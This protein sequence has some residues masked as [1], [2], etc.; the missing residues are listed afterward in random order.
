MSIRITRLQ[1]RNLSETPQIG[2]LAGSAAYNKSYNN[3][4][5]IL[6]H[7][8]VVY[9][10]TFLKPPSKWTPETFTEVAELES[11]IAATNL[12]TALPIRREDKLY[13]IHLSSSPLVK[14]RFIP[15]ARQSSKKARL[16]VHQALARIK[17]G[18]AAVWTCDTNYFL[19]RRVQEGFYFYTMNLQGRPTLMFFSCHRLMVDFVQETFGCTEQSKYFLTNM[20]LHSVEENDVVRIVW[21]MKRCV[22]MRLIDPHEAI[23]HGNICLI[24]PNLERSL[25]IGLN[26]LERVGPTQPKPRSWD[27]KTLNGF[28]KR[29]ASTWTAAEK[30][31]T[32]LRDRNEPSLSIGPYSIACR[33]TAIG[34][35][36]RKHFEELVNYF[37]ASCTALFVVGLD[38]CLLL[39]TYDNFFHWFSPFRYSSLQE[40]ADVVPNRASFLIMTNALSKASQTLYEYLFELGIFPEHSIELVP[41]CVDA[42]RISDMRTGSED[43]DSLDQEGFTISP[44]N[45]QGWTSFY[46]PTSTSP[47]VLRLARQMLDMVYRT[48]EDRCD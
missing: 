34:H 43:E 7:L 41:L 37:L 5:D 38:C 17:R 6:K 20:R 21:K 15:T 24:G 40:A 33:T 47:S 2:I 44:A 45:E 19:I 30:M 11:T 36:Q 10:F 23:L 48:A 46:A 4:D 31:A 1:Y 26:V 3:T 27:N 29:S 8:C 25:E 9:L 32:F 14:G 28:Y 13:H 16:G 12:K 42:R 39:W 22:G 35:R 18:K